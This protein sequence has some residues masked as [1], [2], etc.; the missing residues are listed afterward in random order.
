MKVMI[1]SLSLL[2]SNLVLADS[3]QMN[4]KIIASCTGIANDKANAVHLTI[5]DRF[6]E[7]L[8]AEITST[9]GET[10][11]VAL[12]TSQNGNLG[13]ADGSIWILPNQTGALE[14]GIVLKWNSTTLAGQFMLLPMSCS[15]RP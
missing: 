2:V 1:S 9:N 4:Q 11:A 10:A 14:K 5:V 12:K 15:T 7:N 13:S 6:D 3:S 8:E